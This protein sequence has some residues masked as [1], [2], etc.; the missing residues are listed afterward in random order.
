MPVDETIRNLDDELGTR[1][2]WLVFV[3]VDLYNKLYKSGRLEPARSGVRRA[4]KNTSYE[5]SW[6][7]D[8]KN[9]VAL[10]PPPPPDTPPPD[11]PYRLVVTLT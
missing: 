11:E 7:L 10:F 4:G 2:H 9:L 3:Q 6:W 8:G 5:E 1:E